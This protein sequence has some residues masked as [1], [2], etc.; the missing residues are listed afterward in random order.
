MFVFIEEE[1]LRRSEYPKFEKILEEEF[2]SPEML[3]S[4]EQGMALD[5]NIEI[6]FIQSHPFFGPGEFKEAL[7]KFSPTGYL[8][9]HYDRYT[10]LS[11]P[12]EKRESIYLTDFIF[13]FLELFGSSGSQDDFLVFTK[14]NESIE[15][16]FVICREGDTDCI[17]REV[18]NHMKGRV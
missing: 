3:G 4:V 15:K 6:V 7:V 13:Y 14:E 8:G 11:F 10:V 18:K 9:Q 16:E 2:L 12:P 17:P 1:V 5:P